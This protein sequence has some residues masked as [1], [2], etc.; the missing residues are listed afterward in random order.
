VGTFSRAS[1][2]EIFGWAMFDFA[3]SSYTTVII[4]VVFSV[5]FPRIIVGDAPDYRQGNLLWSL[6]LS[7]SYLIVLLTAPVLGAISDYSA[8][9]KKFLAAS[10]IITAL[11]T[12]GLYII[13]PG[14]IPLCMFFI[15]ISNIGFSYSEAFVSSFLPSLGTPDELGRISGYAWGL[16]YFGGLASTAM[17]IF[18]LGSLQ[19]KTTPG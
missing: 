7:L 11:F 2:K 5:I 6:A 15:I 8:S 4:T 14:M 17:V 12:S 19:W 3:N 16:G 13:E 9:K 1:K 18:G 10:T